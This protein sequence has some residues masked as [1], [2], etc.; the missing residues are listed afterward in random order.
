M[1]FVDVV[2]ILEDVK[3]VEDV[4][5]LSGGYF[6]LVIFLMNK[7]GSCR[8]EVLNETPSVP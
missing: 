4:M 3:V 8:T 1:E 7:W 5:G 6:C 2:R